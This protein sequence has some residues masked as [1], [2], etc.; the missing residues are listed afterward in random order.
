MP[1]ALFQIRPARMDDAIV[2]A[3]AHI[4]A[5]RAAMPWLPVLHTMEETVQFFSDFVIANQTVLVADLEEGVAGFIAIY[6]DWVEH[7][8]V[9]PAHQG[10]GIGD[11]LLKRAKE[12]R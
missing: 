11:A 3:T 8:Y 6:S 7:L 1:A 5:R 12:L 9:A 2:I 10:I 4:D